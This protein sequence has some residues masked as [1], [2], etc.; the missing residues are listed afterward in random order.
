[1]ALEKLG[2]LRG[3]ERRVAADVV[4]SA[5]D[6]V[7]EANEEEI[8]VVAAADEGGRLAAR[9]AALDKRNDARERMLANGETALAAWEKRLREHSERLDRE[10]AGHGQASQ[11][12]FALLAELEQR[13]ARVRELESKHL[14]AEARNDERAEELGRTAETLRRREAQLGVDLDIRE[15]TLDDREH[16]VAEREQR[17]AERERD[18]GA[19]V[20]QLQDQFSDRSVA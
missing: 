3:G 14:E 15:D 2:D 19:Y 11:E 18:L 4:E 9:E 12:A 17:I 20:G 1:M 8:G 7:S 16:A 13:E 5:G 6:V 10:R